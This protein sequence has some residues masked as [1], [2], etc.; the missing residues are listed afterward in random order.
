MIST[1]IFDLD[2]LLADTEP[3]H[4]RAYQEVLAANGV[5]L[6]EEEYIDHWVRTG[7]GIVDWIDLH[8]LKLDPHKIRSEK[9]RR[10]LELLPSSLRPME[11][12]L[13]LLDALRGKKTLALA[14]SSYRD[15]VEAVLN[16]L[17]VRTYFAAVLSGLD[18]AAVKPAPDIFS[19]RLRAPGQRRRNA[20]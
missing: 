6:R 20:S 4:C 14:S 11:G 3:I 13:D 19:P 8:G 12:A 9:S 18:V 10:Y 2:G 1:I 7:R 16:G 5:T 15:A 17:N